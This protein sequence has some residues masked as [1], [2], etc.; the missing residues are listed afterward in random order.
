MNTRLLVIAGLFVAISTGDT[1]A[2]P[3]AMLTLRLVD[4]E[5]LPLT[6]MTARIG[7][8]EGKQN[9]GTTDTNGMFSS[10]GRAISG[11]ATFSVNEDALHAVEVL[12]Q[13]PE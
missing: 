13:L 9:V 10:R 8:F 4:D 3:E 5:G 7:F 11:Q 12:L 2:S 6:N 1:I